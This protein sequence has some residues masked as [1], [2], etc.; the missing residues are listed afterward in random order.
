MNK[1]Q[2]HEIQALDL[3][4]Q[5][6]ETIA[7]RFDDYYELVVCTNDA[8]GE[9]LNVLVTQKNKVRQFKTLNAVDSFLLSIDIYGFSVMSEAAFNEKVYEI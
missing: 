4:M 1:L 3:D 6:N 9:Y 8:N 2:S 7:V 5:I